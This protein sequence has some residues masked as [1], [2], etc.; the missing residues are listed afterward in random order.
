MKKYIIT[1]LIL[2]TPYLVNAQTSKT[3]MKGK[4]GISLYGGV[5][6]PVNGDYSSTIKTTDYFKVG[7]QF[8]L[9]VSY[10]FT[11]G[12]GVEGTFSGGY[13]THRAIYK[14]VGTEPMWINASASI[15]A[16][17]NFRHMFRNPVVSPFVRVGAG[18]YNWE[19]FEDGLFEGNINKETKNHSNSSC[20]FNVGAGAEYTAKKNFTIGLFL[21]YN[22]FYPKYEDQ[23]TNESTTADDYTAIGFL[24]PQIKVSYYFPTRK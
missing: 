10:F 14:P 1:L 23:I 5:N 9:G 22:V 11:K 4:I 17:Y 13:N 19:Q 18:S 15:N 6:I 8:G 2:V 21:D 3:D 7:S 12:F 24:T 16:I 20:G